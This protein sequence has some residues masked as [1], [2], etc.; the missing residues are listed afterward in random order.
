MSRVSLQPAWPRLHRS[1]PATGK[2]LGRVL[3]GHVNYYGVPLNSPALWRFRRAIT[4]LWYRTL[5]RRSQRT[6]L[7]WERMCRLTDI[8]LSKPRVVHPYPWERLRV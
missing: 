3:Q 2:W 1:V 7:T 8:Y 6:R 4:R 5:R